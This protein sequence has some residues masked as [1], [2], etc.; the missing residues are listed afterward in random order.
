M[1]LNRVLDWLAW[2]L[3]DLAAAWDQ[4]TWRRQRRIPHAQYHSGRRSDWRR[5]LDG[6]MR[7]QRRIRWT[8]RAD[9]WKPARYV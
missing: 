5:T 7:F 4:E 8:Y 3:M 9:G 6:H 1:L 2:R